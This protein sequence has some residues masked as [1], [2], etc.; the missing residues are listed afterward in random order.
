MNKKIIIFLVA[1]SMIASIEVNSD[2]GLKI[3]VLNE[4]ELTDMLRG[5]CIQST[6][7]CDANPSIK[8]IKEAIKS[9]K[10]FKMISVD[11][12]P[13]DYRAPFALGTFRCW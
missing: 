12:F 13:N 5:S 6:R 10:K 11:D 2:D 8:L 1:L 4:T 9:G 3:K 7:S